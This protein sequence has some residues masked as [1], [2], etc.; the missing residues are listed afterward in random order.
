MQR[1]WARP[2]PRPVLVHRHYPPVNHPLQAIK[3]SV[4]SVRVVTYTSVFPVKSVHD[5]ELPHLCW[6]SN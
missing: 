2:L 6:R 3:S 1:Y 4:V 5:A